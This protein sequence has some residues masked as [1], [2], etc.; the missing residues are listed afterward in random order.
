VHDGP[1]AATLPGLWRNS[2]LGSPPA[3]GPRG[4]AVFS[5]PTVLVAERGVIVGNKKKRINVKLQS[6]ESPYV[7]VT[8]KN[9]K[10][11]PQRME[12]RKYDPIVKKHVLFKESK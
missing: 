3:G 5:Q 1:N 9:N 10:L 6:T 11:H 4:A 2:G 8:D 12:V 7:Y